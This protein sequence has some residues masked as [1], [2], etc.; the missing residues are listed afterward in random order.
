MDTT[1]PEP[2]RKAPPLDRSVDIHNLEELVA[3]LRRELAEERSA[4]LAAEAQL[5]E[6]Y[7]ALQEEITRLNQTDLKLADLSHRQSTEQLKLIET[8]KS[9]IKLVGGGT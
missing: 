9:L 8:M 2:Q 5:R 6:S 1:V 3:D 4:R 7:L